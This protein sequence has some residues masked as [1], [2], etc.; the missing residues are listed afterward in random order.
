MD[1]S[2]PWRGSDRTNGFL[3]RNV[4]GRI[5]ALKEGSARAVIGAANPVFTEMVLVWGNGLWVDQANIDTQPHTL[6]AEAPATKPWLQGVVAFDQAWQTGNPVQN[7]GVPP[8]SKW[9]LVRKGYV[10]YKQAMY[11]VGKEDDYLAYLQGD[12]SQDVPAVR[13]VYPDWMAVLKAGAAGSRLGLFFGNDSGFP[14]VSLVAAG[15]APTLAN[16][17]FAGFAE[18]FEPENAAI[19]F[20]IQL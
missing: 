9:D 12:T 16:A 14:L 6:H 18:I 10:G 19:F 3:M 17:T 11:A 4:D 8:Y 13:T 7:Y 1:I 20:D 2:K 15:S 5:P